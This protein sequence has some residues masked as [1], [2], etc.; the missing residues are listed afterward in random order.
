MRKNTLFDTQQ[1]IEQAFVVSG[2][3][4]AD[5]F[6]AIKTLKARFPELKHRIE[7][8]DML[9]GESWLL[10]SNQP[11]RQG[12]TEEYIRNLAKKQGHVHPMSPGDADRL[13]A[14]S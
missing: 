12:Q 1:L 9:D 14:L 13:L 5:R 2:G 6:S 7:V 10:L 4:K 8:H 11:L 3:A